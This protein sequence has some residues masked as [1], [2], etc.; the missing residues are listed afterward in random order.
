FFYLLEACN[1]EKD[2]KLDKNIVYYVLGGAAVGA[3]AGYIVKKVGLK[4]VVN[5]LKTKKIIPDNLMETISEFTNKKS[6]D[7]YDLDDDIS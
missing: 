2:K 4:N 7:D 5:V 1:M 3:I 6:S